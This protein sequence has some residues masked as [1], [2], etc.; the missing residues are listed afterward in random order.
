LL[1][2][3]NQLYPLPSTLSTDLPNLKILSPVSNRFQG[4]LMQPALIYVRELYIN[5]NSL[6]TLDKYQSL[7]ILTLN[8][9][10]ISQIS[11]DIMSLSSTLQSLSITSN[12]LIDIPYSMTNM[13][14]SQYNYASQNR[15]TQPDKIYLLKSFQRTLIKLDIL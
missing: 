10:E 4:Q 5:N 9:N 3:S 15:I 13:R 6:A 11:T 8:S 1:L 14:S 12:P 2:P 7:Q